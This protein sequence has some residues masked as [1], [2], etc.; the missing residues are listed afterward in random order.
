MIATTPQAAK[1]SRPAEAPPARADAQ[2]EFWTEPCEL[3]TVCVADQL[4]GIPVK[5][6]QDVLGPQRVARIPL[7]PREVAGALNLRGRIVT[8]IDVRHRLG[9]PPA[10]ANVPGVSVVVERG[11]ELYSLNVDQVSEVLTLQPAQYERNP[12]TVSARWR[13]VSNGI[14]RLE[15]RLCMVLDVDRLLSFRAT[16]AT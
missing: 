2:P 10:P 14:Y 8:A 11:G 9:L 13:E 16:A 3:V 12:P 1:P 5:T 7:A 4:F 15:R 6:I